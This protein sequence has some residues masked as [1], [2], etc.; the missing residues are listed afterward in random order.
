MFTI[1]TLL[2][3]TPQKDVVLISNKR[4]RKIQR[5][6]QFY[7]A[8]IFVSTVIMMSGVG[9]FMLHK[10]TRSGQWLF[11]SLHE[12]LQVEKP[13]VNDAAAAIKSEPKVIIVPLIDYPTRAH[14]TIRR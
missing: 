9:L 5:L 3:I 1:L 6:R 14:N 11:T 12:T 13:P 4:L 10:G 2:H 7:T 8:L